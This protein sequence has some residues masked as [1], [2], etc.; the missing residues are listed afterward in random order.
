MT[1]DVCSDMHHV[2]EIS[3][4][5]ALLKEYDTLIVVG[6]RLLAESGK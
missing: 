1:V 6:Y 4:E 2:L 3:V 5:K